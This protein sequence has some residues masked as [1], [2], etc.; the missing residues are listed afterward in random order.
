MPTS[1]F[2]YSEL[3]I[4]FIIRLTSAWKACFSAL[5]LN[6]FIWATFNPSNLIASSSLCTVSSSVFDPSRLFPI[7]SSTLGSDSD[8][9]LSSVSFGSS[10]PRHWAID[11]NRSNLIYFDNHTHLGLFVRAGEG[12]DDQLDNELSNLPQFT[13]KYWMK[14]FEGRVLLVN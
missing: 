4:S 8:S 1:L 3:I 12:K 7:S 9:V 5:S 11:S 2:R 14:Q 13:A 10:S 6:S